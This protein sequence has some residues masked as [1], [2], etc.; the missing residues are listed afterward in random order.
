MR[1]WILYEP[2]PEIERTF[3]LRKKNQ[4]IEEQRREA[5]KNSNIAGEKRTLQDF[6]TTGVQGIA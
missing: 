2:D 4:M 3:C 5:R 6:I 1:S